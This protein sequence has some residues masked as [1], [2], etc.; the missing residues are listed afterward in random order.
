LRAGEMVEI[1]NAGKRFSGKYRL[2]RVTHTIDE[3][4]YRTSFEV[5]QRASSLLLQSL[6]KKLTDEPP[7]NKQPPLQ[8]VMVGIVRNN[9]ADPKGLGRVQVSFPDLSEINLS[10]WARIAT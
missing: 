9:I 8:G 2:S 4:G 1:R 10:Q 3:G 6:R 7:P 5:T